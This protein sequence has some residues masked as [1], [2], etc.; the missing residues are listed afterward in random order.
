M[1]LHIIAA[2]P[3][4]EKAQYYYCFSRPRMR[5]PFATVCVSGPKTLKR[6]AAVFRNPGDGPALPRS[7]KDGVG[8]HRMPSGE[9]DTRLIE[10]RLICPPVHL[11]RVSIRSQAGA[12]PHSDETLAGAVGPHHTRS[13]CS[14]QQRRQLTGDKRFA[15]ARKTSDR[16]QARRMRQEKIGCHLKV[17]LCRIAKGFGFLRVGLVGRRGRI[18]MAADRRPQ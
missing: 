7:G 15:G 18:D 12:Q 2:R 5:T 14:A 17:S 9:R 13:R 8:D 11:R 4:I 1:Y 16:N 10:R 6:H 3:K